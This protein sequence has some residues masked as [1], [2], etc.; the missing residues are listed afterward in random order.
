MERF[1]ENIPRILHST[2]HTENSSYIFVLRRAI[3]KK[4]EITQDEIIFC[5]HPLTDATIRRFSISFLKR[6]N[7]LVSCIHFYSIRRY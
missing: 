5:S 1:D 3:G 7:L 4:D 2:Y 6:N